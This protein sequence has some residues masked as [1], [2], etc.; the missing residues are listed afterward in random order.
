MLKKL[1][2]YGNS[3]ALVLDKALLELLSIEEGSVVKL[4]TDGTSLIITAQHKASEEKISPTIT[5]EDIM[6]EIVNSHLA[7]HYGSA[8]NGR[9]YINE[10]HDVHARH[11]H[12][13]K[14]LD[15]AEIKHKVEE[16]DKELQAISKKYIPE[17]NVSINM[18][19]AFKKVHEKYQHVLNQVCKLSN[20]NADYIHESVLLAEK[21]HA[22]KNSPEYVEEYAELIAKY[23]P[24]YADY[25][26]EIKMVFD[27]LK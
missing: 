20:E 1:V 7:K 12:A 14:Q 17:K 3:N 23:I 15:T 27:S 5:Q 24:E 26:K 16:T 11:E 2:K 10:L 6:K 9:A 25:P 22:T 21:H 19:D 4:K 8:E 13:I 18:I